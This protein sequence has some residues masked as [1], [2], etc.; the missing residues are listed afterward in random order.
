MHGFAFNFGVRSYFPHEIGDFV[1]IV[2][3]TQNHGL[4]RVHPWGCRRFAAAGGA[5]F[6]IQRARGVR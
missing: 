6:A 4:F 5:L 3:R 2:G 1:Q